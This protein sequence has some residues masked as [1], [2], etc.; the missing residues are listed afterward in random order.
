MPSI[1]TIKIAYD[2]RSKSYTEAFPCA[3]LHPSADVVKDCE[4]T[5]R[6][7]WEEMGNSGR[8]LKIDISVKQA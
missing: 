2:D 8:G 3:D 4:N 5:I 1:I 7:K 6:T